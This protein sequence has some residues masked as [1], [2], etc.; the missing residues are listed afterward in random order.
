MVD[1]VLPVSGLGAPVPAGGRPAPDVAVNLH[2]RG[3][4]SHRL[5][6]RSHRAALVAFACA[7]GRVQRRAGLGRATSTRWTGGAGW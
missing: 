6:G 3:P 5:L 2:G 1:T 4:Q 7:G